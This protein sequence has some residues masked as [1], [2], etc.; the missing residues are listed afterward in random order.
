MKGIHQTAA[1][2]AVIAA[3]GFAT[4]SG[5]F[6]RPFFVG[7]GIQGYAVTIALNL[8]DMDILLAGARS[9]TC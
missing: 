2:V 9:A 6:V 1:A 3:L 8:T 7:L 5:Q 4:V